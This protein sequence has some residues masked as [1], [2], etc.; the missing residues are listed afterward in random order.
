MPRLQTIIRGPSGVDMLTHILSTVFGESAY[1][2]QQRGQVRVG[3]GNAV[4]R[5]PGVQHAD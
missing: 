5:L 2:T 4:H 3:G 1:S